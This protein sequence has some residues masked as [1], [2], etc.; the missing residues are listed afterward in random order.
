MRKMRL[1]RV[2]TTAAV[3]GVT[4]GLTLGIVAAVTYINWGYVIAPSH[5]HY[6]SPTGTLK[7][8]PLT[9]SNTSYNLTTNGSWYAIGFTTNATAGIDGY[10]IYL[11]VSGGNGH[12]TLYNL[13]ATQMSEIQNNQTFTYQMVWSNITSKYIEVF[14]YVFGTYYFCWMNNGITSVNFTYNLNVVALN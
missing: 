6:G 5:G 7:Y 9:V 4:I 13:T 2:L 8:V 14:S 11:N 1:R 10:I 3:V 12:L